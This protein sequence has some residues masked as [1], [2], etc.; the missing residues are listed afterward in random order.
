MQEQDKELREMAVLFANRIGS[1][2]GEGATYDRSRTEPEDSADIEDDRQ[3]NG[4]LYSHLPDDDFESFVA[5]MTEYITA[6]TNAEIAKV[7]DRLELGMRGKTIVDTADGW[8]RFFER[9]VRDAIQA[10]R[11]KLEEEK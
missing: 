6:H 5:D 11:A 1:P 4:R 10:E 8:Q 2:W 3:P 9:H 7:L